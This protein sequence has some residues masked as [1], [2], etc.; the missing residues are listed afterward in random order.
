MLKIL[1]PLFII[2][3]QAIVISGQAFPWTERKLEAAIELLKETEE[4][5]QSDIDVFCAKIEDLINDNPNT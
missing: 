4:L 1:L 5:D 3:L 2:L